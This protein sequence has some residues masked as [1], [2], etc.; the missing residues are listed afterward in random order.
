MNRTAINLIRL[1]KE[2]R[3]LVFIKSIGQEQ[4]NEKKIK[5]FVDMMTYYDSVNAHNFQLFCMDIV[6]DCSIHSR[7]EKLIQKIKE[8]EEI[9]QRQSKWKRHLDYIKTRGSYSDEDL[10]N[11]LGITENKAKE[12]L[13]AYAD[14]ELGMKIRKSILENGQCEFTAEC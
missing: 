8:L 7:N 6:N 11:Y 5:L 13:S 4:D 12:L 9:K 10:A 2:R 14:Y 3:A 1:E